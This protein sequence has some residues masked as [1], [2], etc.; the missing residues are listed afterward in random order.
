V[1]CV[2]CIFRVAVM[3][4]HGILLFTANPAKTYTGGWF[5][6]AQAQAA[7]GVCVRVVMAEPVAIAISGRQALAREWGQLDSADLCAGADTPV[8]VV[9]EVRGLGARL[10]ARA[11]VIL[12]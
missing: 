8:R 3:R 2:L 7:N 10:L 5:A 1:M 11:F 4:V 6:Q 12:P 9:L